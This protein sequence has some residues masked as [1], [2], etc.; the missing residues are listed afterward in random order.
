MPHAVLAI[1]ADPTPLP[2]R[3]LRPLSLVNQEHDVIVEELTLLHEDP[4]II[5]IELRTLISGVAPPTVG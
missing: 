1:P 5:L 3:L 2:P 4:G